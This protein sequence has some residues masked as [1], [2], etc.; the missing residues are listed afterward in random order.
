MYLVMINKKGVGSS[1]KSLGG[2]FYEF[3]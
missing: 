3:N 2:I 1:K